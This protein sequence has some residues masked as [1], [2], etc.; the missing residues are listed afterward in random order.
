[1]RS[2]TSYLAFLSLPFIITAQRVIYARYA[3]PDPYAD[4]YPCALAE[5]ESYPYAEAVDSYYHRRDAYPHA[6]AEAELDPYAEIIDGYYHKRDTFPYAFANSEANAYTDP[7]R[8]IFYQKRDMY[9]RDADAKA[10]DLHKRYA[11][12]WPMAPILTDDQKDEIRDE[13]RTMTGDYKDAQKDYKGAVSSYNSASG[14]AAKLAAAVK[15][16]AFAKAEADMRGVVTKK[17]KLLGEPDPGDHSGAKN[18]AR[19]NQQ[20]WQRIVKSLRN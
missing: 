3:E 12:P 5:A 17:Y 1:M 19:R 7:D 8:A 9:A 20:K 13:I 18:F 2:S 16:E 4:A 14:D 11:S 10:F 6:L 15:A